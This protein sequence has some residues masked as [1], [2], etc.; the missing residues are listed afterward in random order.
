MNEDVV[1]MAMRDMNLADFA[2][3]GQIEA[4]LPAPVPRFSCGSCRRLVKI[5]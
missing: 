5:A 4:Q 3:A 2:L 1:E